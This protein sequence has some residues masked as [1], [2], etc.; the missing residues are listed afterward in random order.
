MTKTPRV[1]RGGC[2]SCKEGCLTRCRRSSPDCRATTRM[3]SLDSDHFVQRL[4]GSR[5]SLSARC[6][7]SCALCATTPSFL[8]ASIYSAAPTFGV[9]ASRRGRKSDSALYAGPCRPRV[10]CSLR[11]IPQTA[12]DEP[13]VALSMHPGTTVPEDGTDRRA[14]PYAWIEQRLN[15]SMLVN[16]KLIEAKKPASCVAIDA[17]HGGDV[18]DAGG[19]VGGVDVAVADTESACGV[20][21]VR[22]E[23]VADVRRPAD[24]R[25]GR[26]LEVARTAAIRALPTGESSASRY[27]GQLSSSSTRAGVGADSGGRPR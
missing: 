6:E 3:L 10:G 19:L 13:R 1:C 26:R 7:R 16:R 8:R 24:V 14:A 4:E 22:G 9:A 18:R 27:A 23:Q 5:S 12:A 20:D 17:V 11:T 21:A 25:W 15:R 2:S